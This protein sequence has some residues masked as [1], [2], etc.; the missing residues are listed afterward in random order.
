[1]L[2]FKSN[3]AGKFLQHSVIEEGNKTFV[4]FPTAGN[5]RGWIKI[6]DFVAEIVGQSSLEPGLHRKGNRSQ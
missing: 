4:L 5:D 3:L 1:M 2:E 6:F